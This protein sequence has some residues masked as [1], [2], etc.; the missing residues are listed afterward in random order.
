MGPD[1]LL[2][3]S[4]GAVYGAALLSL[5]WGLHRLRTATSEARPPVSVIVAARD[6]A[7]NIDACLAALA[8]QDYGGWWEIVV[9]DDRSRDDTATRL[10]RW[11]AQDARIRWCRA[12]DPP[13]YRCPKK[14]ALASGIE[15]SRGEILLCTD[16]DC[17][18]PAGW[19]GSM[20]ACFGAEVGLVAGYARPE[21]SASWIQRVLALDN[22]AVGALG[23][24]GIGLGMAWACTGRN[25]AYRR[26]AYEQAG[27]FAAI[28][29]LVGGDDVYLARRVASA[30]NWRLAYNRRNDAVVLCTAPPRAW[31]AILQQKLRHAAKAGHYRGGA[32]ALGAVVYVFYAALAW[33]TGRALAGQGELVT[34]SVWVAKASLD[35]VLLGAMASAPERRLLRWLPVLELLHVPYV[36]L[37]TIAGRLGW[38]R[39]KR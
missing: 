38:F 3:V 32:L 39:W 28:G 4:T 1:Q 36:L 14:S 18:P 11:A 19:I 34:G 24:G 33:G 31:R 21:G 35:A 5:R 23:A 37:G 9:V 13:R 20:V 16:A 25:L 15:I 30:T 12:P 10:Q 27:G 22:L 8:R 17:R 6:E 29:H 2:L 7:E 26:A